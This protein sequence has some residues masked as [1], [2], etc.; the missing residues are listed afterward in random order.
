MPTENLRVRLGLPEVAAATLRTTAVH[1][2]AILEHSTRGGGEARRPAAEASG[3]GRPPKATSRWLLDSELRCNGAGCRGPVRHGQGWRARQ[4]DAR[5][6]AAA[7]AL[8][9][10]ARAWAA[11]AAACAATRAMGSDAACCAAAALVT[12][13][14]AL[15]PAAPA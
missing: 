6:L 2:E 14:A 1:A 4:R 5:R 11:A 12:A 3:I 9:E 15:P 13:F 10:S 7:A 8:P